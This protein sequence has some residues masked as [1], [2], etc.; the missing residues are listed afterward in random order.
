MTRDYKSLIF[1]PAVIIGFAAVLFLGTSQ[2]ANAACTVKDWPSGTCGCNLIP[3]ADKNP[4]EFEFQ[5]VTQAEADNLKKQGY[6]CGPGYGAPGYCCGRGK[7]TADCGL[8]WVEKYG[9]KINEYKKVATTEAANLTKDGWTCE[10]KKYGAGD[11]Q[12]CC[13][14]KTGSSGAA[15]STG[16]GSPTIS[17][18]TA[19]WSYGSGSGLKLVQCTRTG[20]CTIQDIVQQAINFAGFIM[21]LSG[22]LFL[23]AFVWGGAMY[24]LSFGREA[25]VTKGRDAMV[26]SAIGIVFIMAAWTIVWYVA[27]SLGY[28]GGSA[29]SGST[30]S[31]TAQTKVCGQGDAPASDGWTC[32]DE[33]D[34]KDCKTGYCKGQPT[35]IKCCL[36][37]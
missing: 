32:V 30:G 21:G 23:I 35:N 33:K 10:E 3:E 37:K 15:T 22:A 16:S 28:S 26:K 14:K 25:Y 11:S 7:W 5:A 1:Y 18:S 6:T 34:G 36:P 17:G 20:D 9:P 12:S 13:Y 24:T 8:G 4:T 31:P 29:P 19:P 2:S 27:Q